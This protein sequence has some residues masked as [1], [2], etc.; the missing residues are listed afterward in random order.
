MHKSI[1]YL[2]LLCL[3]G[4]FLRKKTGLTIHIYLKEIFSEIYLNRFGKSTF[5]QRNMSSANFFFVFNEVKL[6]DLSS[7]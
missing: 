4:L 7:T 6:S 3:P 1:F 2:L 5:S